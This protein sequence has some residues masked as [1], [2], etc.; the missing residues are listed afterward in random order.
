MKKFYLVFLATFMLTFV[1]GQNLNHLNYDL[2]SKWFFGINGGVTWS[3]T[4]VDDKLDLERAIWIAKKLGKA[5]DDFPTNEIIQLAKKWKT[6]N[7]ISLN[8]KL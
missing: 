7:K 1:K 6:E 3:T 8:N 2:S 4:D 5:K